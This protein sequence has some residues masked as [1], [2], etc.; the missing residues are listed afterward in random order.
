MLFRREPQILFYKD[1]N[2]RFYKVGDMVYNPTAK[3]VWEVKINNANVDSKGCRYSLVLWGDWSICYMDLDEPT[4][5]VILA[6]KG[7]SG[8]FKI[9]HKCKKIARKL[10][11]TL[12]L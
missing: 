5:F 2:D 4:G 7:E 10:K 3:D 12:N 9:K 11:K 1:S 6:S 8:Y